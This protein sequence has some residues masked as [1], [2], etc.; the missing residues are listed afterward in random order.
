ME[1]SRLLLPGVLI[2]VASAVVSV[3][4]TWSF[5][6]APVV[7]SDGSKPDDNR[8]ARIEERLAALERGTAHRTELSA[9][10]TERK[11]IDRDQDTVTLR[12]IEERIARLEAAPRRE[13]EEGLALKD[14]EYE[15]EKLNLLYDN[16]T[17]DQ[18][19]AGL[20][21]K[22]AADITAAR[23]TITDPSTSKQDKLNAHGSLRRRENA[24][25]PEMAHTMIQI[26]LHD[27]DEAIRAQVWTTFDGSSAKN[28]PQLVPHL[29]DALNRDASSRVR[30]EAAETLGNFPR[31]RAVHAALEHAAKHDQDAQVRRKAQ[32][33]LD[34]IRREQRKR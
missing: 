22:R 14:S 11:P 1:S 26:G 18:R 13:L 17:R 31:D 30:A 2:V 25:T 28:L 7:P 29:I 34:E 15:V 24:Y 6:P 3:L 9:P 33:T 27:R 21:P 12:K 10:A 32:R 8:L 16:A 4:V 5:A 19:I 20:R 23:H